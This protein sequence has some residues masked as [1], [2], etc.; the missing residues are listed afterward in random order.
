MFMML[1][2]LPAKSQ[3]I[4][5]DNNNC[6]LAIPHPPAAAMASSSASQAKGGGKK[7]WNRPV[8]RKG[9]DKKGSD[10]GRPAALDRGYLAGADD[11]CVTKTFVR[12]FV[13]VLANMTNRIWKLA[14]TK[15]IQRGVNNNSTAL[16]VAGNIE[17]GAFMRVN[18]ASKESM[19]WNPELVDFMAKGG[20]ETETALKTR[21]RRRTSTIAR[22]NRR[23]GVTRPPCFCST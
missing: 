8:G 9:G 2:S 16:N 4:F 13:E 18:P 23:I 12:D 11:T 21:G 1:A 20:Y 5:V 15:Y 6:I 17:N 10:W 14:P 22:N 7:A 19:A 3:S